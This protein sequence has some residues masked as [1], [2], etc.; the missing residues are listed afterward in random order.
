MWTAVQV[1]EDLLSTSYQKYGR[2]AVGSQLELASFA[3]PSVGQ[4]LEGAHA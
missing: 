1:A 3:L 2:V 4:V